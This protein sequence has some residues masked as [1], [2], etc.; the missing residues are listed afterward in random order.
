[1]AVFRAGKRRERQIEEIARWIM[2]SD[3]VVA[4]TGAGIST[5]SG[6]PDFRGPDGVW[7]RR[8]AGLPAPRW[9][10]PRELRR[11][12]RI[13]PLPRR[14]PAARQAPVPDH[15]EHRQP[16]PPF[17]HTSRATGGA[18]RQ[19]AAHALH[20]LRTVVH[21]ARVGMGYGPVG[22]GLPYPEAGIRA[23]GSAPPAT[24]G[25]SRRW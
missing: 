9:R 14:A 23:A 18:A 2:D 21:P 15:P 22:P 17:R 4:F 25:S 20:E 5:D 10:V 24:V 13:P 8:D 7:T 16:P 19:R 1:M 11:A 12:Q 6:I 3:H